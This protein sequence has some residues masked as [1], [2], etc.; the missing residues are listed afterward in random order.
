MTKRRDQE[1][2]IGDQEGDRMMLLLK[3]AIPR[4]DDEADLPRD[5]RPA[6]LQRMDE[7]STRGVASVPWFDWALAGGLLAFAAI[8][9]RTIPVIL[10]Y[11]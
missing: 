7:P 2:G 5:L 1:K 9:P 8:A 3:S 10:Y 4:V 11:L 6:M